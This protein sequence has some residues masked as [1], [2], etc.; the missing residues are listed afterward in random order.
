MENKPK[1][2]TEGN[3]ALVTQ[4]L[5]LMGPTDRFMATSRLFVTMHRHQLL[6]RKYWWVLLLIALATIVPAYLLTWA[7]P[8]SYQSDA[9]MWLAGK[10]DLSEGHLY[11]EELVNF[12][13]TQAD[14]IRSRAVQERALEKVEQQYTNGPALKPVQGPLDVL[15]RTV[16]S[17]ATLK[18][19]DG[20]FPFRL[21]VT[22]SSKSSLLEL[23]AKGAEPKSTQLFLNT[24]MAEY[25]NFKKESREKTSNRA[26]AGLTQEVN[27]LANQLKKEQEKVYEFQMSNNAVFLQD[28]GN[29]AVNYLGS[30]N[31]QLATWRTELQLLQMIQPDQWVEMNAKGHQITAAEPPP[32]DTQAQDVM[33]GLTGAQA[34]LYR[35]NQ[36]IEVLKAKR[37][38]LSRALRP[39]HP[40]I[41]KLDQDIAAQEKLVEISR[42]ETMKQLTNRREALQLEVKNLEKVF[43][44]WEAKTVNAGRT[45]AD[46]DRLRQDVQRTQTAYDKLLTVISTVDVGK[47]VDQ[48]NVSVLEPASMSVPVHTGLRNMGLAIACWMLLAAGTLWLLGKLDDRFASSTELSED[49]PEKV[50]GQVMDVRIAKQ[51]AQ[52]RPEILNA[53]KF[54]FLESFRSIRSA[55]HFMDRNGSRPKTILITSSVPEEGK[56]TVALYLSATMAVGGARVLLIDGDMRRAKLHRHFGVASSP[57]LAGILNDEVTVA[58]ALAGSAIPNLTFLPAGAPSVEPGE[59]VL[60]SRLNELLSEVYSQFDYIILDSP[61][62]LA[63]DDAATIAPNVDGVL[64][65]VRG[66][67]T[68][69]RMVREGLDALR[70]RQ[71]RIL[72]LIF[73]RALSSAFEDHPYQRY[74]SEYRWHSKVH[75]AAA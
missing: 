46:Y 1:K 68:A 39:M 14:L 59:L 60:R 67:Y 55:L 65:V 33:A 4:T 34:D 2:L 6:L 58:D 63:A 30:L 18:K 75:T 3:R 5:D 19:L 73:N 64:Y 17:T 57:G 24:L 47:S 37:D 61:P 11:T 45:M 51:G 41:I 66:T 23:Q 21:K 27:E 32:G 43:S 44:E 22:E 74:K 53:Q 71:A 28:Q 31:R 16:A 15:R 10:L 38:E 72:G 7:T 52:L 29:G 70:Q 12:L 50:V 56:S 25:L 42:A 35:A 8:R 49:F 20:S 48:E 26:V 69:A 9:Q 13:G 62:V 36:Q 54:E 40:K